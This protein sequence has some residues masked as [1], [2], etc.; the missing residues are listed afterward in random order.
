M[1]LVLIIITFCCLQSYG[2]EVG[3]YDSEYQ[4][5]DSDY[6][7]FKFIKDYYLA[8]KMGFSRVQSSANADLWQQ[9][10]I[11]T[12]PWNVEEQKWNSAN[13]KYT[14]K[15]D[16]KGR[17]I[18]QTYYSREDE[19]GEWQASSRT[20]VT[21][22][23]VNK[24]QVNLGQLW[25]N[26]LSKWVN[27]RKQEYI[28][29]ELGDIIYTIYYEWGSEKEEWE[30]VLKTTYEYDGDGNEIEIQ[31]A[32]WIKEI[33]DWKPEG[34]RS[35][36]YTENT[37]EEYWY[38][39]YTDDWH[40]YFKVIT[41]L[42]LNGKKVLTTDYYLSGVEWINSGQSVYSYTGEFLTAEAYYTWNSSSNEWEEDVKYEYVHNGYGN[43]TLITKYDFDKGVGNWINNWKIDYIYNDLQQIPEFFKSEWRPS[44]SDWEYVT[45]SRVFFSEVIEEERIIEQQELNYGEEVFVKYSDIFSTTKDERLTY[46]ITTNL[47]ASVV[48]EVDADELKLTALENIDSTD[49]V[50]I[51]ASVGK[52]SRIQRFPVK[53]NMITGVNDNKIQEVVAYPNP[54]SDI[55]TLR[56]GSFSK[57]VTWALRSYTG[58]VIEKGRFDGNVDAKQIEVSGLNSGIYL[59]NISDGTH[60]VDRKLIIR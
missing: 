8:K 40:E 6:H 25:E 60:S 36:I 29:N 5:K 11:L 17:G 12:D 16:S 22:D 39:W 41:Q 21:F 7:T 31:E 32:S 14:V 23:D 18:E 54:A 42:D 20:L 58:E 1:K 46:V 33:N 30:A 35:I 53:V 28:L 15:R 59:L 52:Y 24:L 3:F 27:I 57:E 47:N 37:T 4:G 2:Q 43:R 9:D 56:T 55:I 13:R 10:S 48:V 38:S 44:L 45:R 19:N 34:K 51:T 50:T 26:D 49:S